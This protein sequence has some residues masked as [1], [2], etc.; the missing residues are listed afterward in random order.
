MTY[1]VTENCENC[2]FTDCVTVCPVDCFY[3][4]AE[5]P[6]MLYI[7]PEECIDC[8]A[9]LPECPVQAIY[10]E[11]DV[12]EQMKKWIAVNKER[13][14]AKNAV[15]VAEKIEPLPTAEQKKKELGF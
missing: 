5:N 10:A 14:M 12:P 7:H 3:Q 8:G 9:C 13:A 11:D 15:N 4:D 2:K 6:K 1:I